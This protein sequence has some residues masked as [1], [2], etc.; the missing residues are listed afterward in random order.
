[1]PEVS[2]SSITLS[3]FS[4]SRY[5]R[6]KA[7]RFYSLKAEAIFDKGKCGNNTI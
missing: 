2:T 1:M 4:T 6:M 5:L 3:I 7:I